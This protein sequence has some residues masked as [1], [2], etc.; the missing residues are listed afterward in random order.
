[1]SFAIVFLPE[2]DAHPPAFVFAAASRPPLAAAA[3]CTA[4][5]AFANAS[6]AALQLA[7][8]TTPWAIRSSGIFLR[9][10]TQGDMHKE[11]DTP[12]LTTMFDLTSWL[13]VTSSFGGNFFGR[14]GRHVY[15][16]L[17]SCTLNGSIDDQKNLTADDDRQLALPTS[18]PNS[19]QTAR[20]GH[21]E[22]SVFCT[23]TP[24]IDWSRLASLCFFVQHYLHFPQA[25][26][27]ILESP[28]DFYIL[29]WAF[30]SLRCSAGCW[31]PVGNTRLIK[32]GEVPSHS[33]SS[34]LRSR[35]S[36]QALI[37][38]R[39][40]IHSAALLS[41]SFS[42]SSLQKMPLITS[43]ALAPILLKTGG[44]TLAATGTTASF[45][46]GTTAAVGG[47]AAA[48]GGKVLGLAML[49]KGVS[50]AAKGGAF[51]KTAAGAAGASHAAAASGGGG[52]TLAAA[53]AVAA[54]APAAVAAG[55]PAV[56]ATPAATGPA[57]TAAAPAA[58]AAA[59]AGGSVAVPAT[60][61]GVAA[62][63]EAAAAP[64][65]GGKHFTMI[66]TVVGIM[67][68]RALA[69]RY[70]VSKPTEAKSRLVRRVCRW[71]K[72]EEVAVEAEE[73]FGQIPRLPFK[74]EARSYVEAGTG[75]AKP[76]RLTK[77]EESRVSA[78]R[79][80]D[81]GL[82]DIETTAST[83]ETRRRR[84]SYVRRAKGKLHRFL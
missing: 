58:A 77:E 64:A 70:W 2:K 39:L 83:H 6:G 84:V 59:G 27:D 57:I 30:A 79:A 29:I 40:Y 24:S 14:M 45:A 81:A 48:T 54:A 10:Q 31:P 23:K 28:I 46:A 4:P 5:P 55:A 50:S 69:N 36:I 33:T 41:I 75:G 38:V 15:L 52:V 47:G 18:T 62:A 11:G 72:E 13:S 26:S 71:S 9:R 65:G 44:A 7:A 25:C 61:A 16:K 19:I 34:T 35:L 56:V 73:E 80:T 17:Q 78:A 49:T 32:C 3:P 8:S 67:V 43:L 63:G 37:D 60:A 53:P 82:T 21:Y 66:A 1:M 22:K 51:T 42:L 20:R 76:R 74:D 12:T 68:L